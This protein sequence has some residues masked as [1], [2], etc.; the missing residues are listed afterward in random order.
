MDFDY[1]ANR[2]RFLLA[3]STFLELNTDFIISESNTIKILSEFYIYI[4]K[5]QDDKILAVKH[6]HDSSKLDEEIIEK[7][8]DFKEQQ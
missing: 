5:C 7:I 3:L 4:Q 6:L 8:K 1:L 2:G